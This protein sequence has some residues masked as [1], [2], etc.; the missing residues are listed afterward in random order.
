MKKIKSS[1][2]NRLDSELAI[3]L[4]IEIILGAFLTIF[5]LYFF[6]KIGSEIFNE[7]ILL[8]DNSFSNLVYSFRTDS[9]NSLMIFLTNLASPYLL[10]AGAIISA[11]FISLYRK[12][13]AVIFLS[14]L[15]SAVLANVILKFIYQRPRP[16]EFPLIHES[17]YSFPSGHAMNA[18]MFYSLLAYFIYRETKSLKATFLVSIFCAIIILLVGFSRIYLG[19]HYPS[20]VLGGFIA[21]FLWLSFAIIFEKAIIFKRLKHAKK[22]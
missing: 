14:I 20:D 1:I 3:K 18:F 7:N 9:L 2:R 8:L 17:S 4:F 21:G 19:I 10:F 5:S 11:F 13:D 6:L 15:S 16:D 12:K 22:S